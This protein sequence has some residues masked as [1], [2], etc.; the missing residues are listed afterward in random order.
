MWASPPWQLVHQ[1]KGGRKG[2]REKKRERETANK[3]EVTILCNVIT[4]VTSHQPCHV[5]L[6]VNHQF[7]PHSKAEDYIMV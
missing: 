1:S 6:E 7:Y 3:M 2:G 4:E 5:L